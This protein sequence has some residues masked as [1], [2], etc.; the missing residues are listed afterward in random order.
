MTPKSI[1]KPVVLTGIEIGTVFAVSQV[2]NKAVTTVV[3]DLGLWSEE[4]TR[5]E[6]VIQTVK[7]VGVSVGIALIAGAAATAVKSTTERIIW[8]DAEVIEPEN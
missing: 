4:W 7:L 6:K 5:K 3:P 2:L 8:N 1:V